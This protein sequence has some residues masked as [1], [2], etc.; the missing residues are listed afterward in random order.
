MLH[1]VRV[2]LLRFRFVRVIRCKQFKHKLAA[3]ILKAEGSPIA[4]NLATPQHGNLGDHAIVYAQSKFLQRH[5]PEYYQIEIPSYQYQRYEAEIERMVLPKDII[6]IDGGGNLGTLWSEEDD[7]IRSIIERFQDNRIIVFPQTCFYEPSE[8]SRQRIKRNRD[9]YQKHKNIT[10]MLR[11]KASLNLFRTEFPK[12]DVLFAPDIVL[13]LNGI[14]NQKG[15]RNE[16][17]FVFRKDHEAALDESTKLQLT[18]WFA[19]SGLTTRY[20]DTVINRNVSARERETELLRKLDEISSAQIVVTDRLHAMIFA[21]I[22]K[23]PC[24]ALDNASRKVTG[25]YAWIDHLSYIRVASTADEVFQLLP[26]VLAVR[27]KASHADVLATTWSRVA[28]KL[29]GGKSEG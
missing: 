18:E 19:H 2:G 8:S 22:T 14:E 11:D 25:V 29:T 7:K 17:L 21:A 27:E 1:R 10:F 9:V 15:R 13:S 16:V 12:V 3:S 23:T 28:E 26:E 24:I 20:S 5:M 4:F 6:V